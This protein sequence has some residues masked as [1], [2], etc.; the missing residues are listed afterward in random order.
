MAYGRIC[1]ALF[2]AGLNAV[3]F[4]FIYLLLNFINLALSMLKNNIF[5]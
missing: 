2:L 3:F 1:Q 4:F 5:F